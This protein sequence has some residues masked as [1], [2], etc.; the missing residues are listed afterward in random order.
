MDISLLTSILQKPQVYDHPVAHVHFVETHISL[1]FL[2]GRFVY[3]IKK[4]VNFGFLDFSSLAKRK[5][6]CDEEVRLNSR[7]A[8]DLYV[9]VVPICKNDNHIKIDGPGEI[10]EYAVKMHQFDPDNE[11]D[12]L[13]SKGKLTKLH[14]EQAARIIA[15]FHATIAVADQHQSYG[16][17]HAIQQPTREN[18]EQLS[19]IDAK[20][21][22]RYELND[23]LIQLRDWTES[24]YDILSA[25]FEKRKID[26]FIRECHGDLHLR[27]IV[28]HENKVTPFDGIEFNKNLSWIDVVNDVAF[29]LMDLEDHNR[30]DLSRILRDNYFSTT[31]DYTGL[32]VL[33]Y[34]LVYRAMVRAKVAAL[35]LMQTPKEEETLGKE[36]KN[37]LLLA[38]S[39]THRQQPK[40]IIAHGLSGSG[41]TFLSQQLLELTDIIR[42]R[43]DVE[44]KR[45]TAKT[46]QQYEKNTI[47][48][49]IYN[50]QISQ[51]TYNHLLKLSGT[52]INAGYSVFVDAA[53]L[54]KSQR[55]LFFSYARE[56]NI[57]III[58]HCE[59]D[60][61]L[62]RQR[63]DKRIQQG[64]DASE[65]DNTILDHQ[66]DSHEPLTTDEDSHT[67]RV[68]TNEQPS[69]TELI[70]WL[71]LDN[72]S[73]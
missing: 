9:G 20:R 59:S 13:L 29:L 8:P 72:N 55:E 53:F 39:F 58:C 18:F 22:S 42:I 34:Y 38:L 15:D 10:I 6:Y 30:V 37:Y 23:V 2:T 73:L 19:R 62:Q 31:G 52:I 67:I 60:I 36:L 69:L 35:R 17:P 4:P 40:I 33:R 56:N 24:Q 27:N 26:G 14:I 48:S 11:F 1:L 32:S 68:N 3:K 64:D 21:L 12:K 51:K 71:K 16:S 25:T 43:S 66:L 49:G 5:T 47:N 46:K 57:A 7:F 45:I 44:R 28:L 54:K 65:A 50:H 41:K 70:K 63:L 61:T